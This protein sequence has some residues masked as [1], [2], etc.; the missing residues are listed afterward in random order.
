MKKG[1]W[2]IARSI[3]LTIVHVI[4]E[5]LNEDAYTSQV[6]TYIENKVGDIYIYRYAWVY[7]S[8]KCSCENDLMYSV[9]GVHCSKF[10]KELVYRI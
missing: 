2:V 8:S 5:N 6:K 3:F 10:H 1:P 4:H 9:K 7:R